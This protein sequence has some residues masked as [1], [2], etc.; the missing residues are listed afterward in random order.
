[1]IEHE[2][3]PVQIHPNGCR[4]DAA[5][6]HGGV[7]YRTDYFLDENNC[8]LYVPEIQKGSIPDFTAR[9]P[10]RKWQPLDHKESIGAVRQK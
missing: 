9:F 4:R 1:M 7:V 8:W 3:P 6:V 10:W 5:V 2:L